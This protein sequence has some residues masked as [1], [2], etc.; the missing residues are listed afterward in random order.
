M[1]AQTMEER[2]TAVE[3]KLEQL[4]RE[5]EQKKEQ[6]KKQDQGQDKEA[7][8]PRGWQRIVGIFAD[9]PE[10]EEAVKAGKEWRDSFR[11]PDYGETS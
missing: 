2:L 5:K 6:N 11:P 1:S 8:E 10:F 7:E 3:T 4:E 9:D